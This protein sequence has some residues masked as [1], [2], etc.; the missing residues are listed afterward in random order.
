MSAPTLGE[1]GPYARSMSL[2]SAASSTAGPHS[3][4]LAAGPGIGPA[5]RVESPH[6]FSGTVV[7]AEQCARGILAVADVAATSHYRRIEWSSLDPVVTSDGE[8]LRFESFSGCGGVYARFDLLPEAL[9]GAPGE[10]GTTNIDVNQPLRHALATVRSG[11][12]LRLEVGAD[13]LKASTVTGEVTERKVKLPE[14]WIRGFGEASVAASSMRLRAEV[15]PADALR[16]LRSLPRDGRRLWIVPSGRSLRVSAVASPGAIHLDGVARLT[17]LQPLLRWATALRVHAPESP[18]ASPTASA[19][20][21][22]LRSAR[23]TL[24]ISPEVPRGFSGEGAVLTDL[25]AG[26]PEDADAVLEQLAWTPG[27]ASDTVAF[28]LGW[29]ESRVVRALTL[30]GTSGRV[31]F[32]TAESTYFHRELPYDSA[33]AA[34][35]NPRLLGAQ[36]L[37]AA[38]AVTW[39]GDRAVVDS[40]GTLYRLRRHGDGWACTCPWWTRYEGHRGPCKHTLAVELTR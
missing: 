36:R 18:D 20:E 19:W 17:E 9:S 4:S 6:F 37:V 23:L 3:V 21:L 1:P 10:L 7:D 16:F 13:S 31:G 40:D 34:R 28:A 24:T 33:A 30:L 22:V 15:G 14:R 27:A 2:T 38:G 29:D 11:E 5:G 8:R 39:E 12:P 35:R 32:D 26:D 25:A